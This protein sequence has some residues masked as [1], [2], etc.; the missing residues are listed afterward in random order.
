MIKISDNEKGMDTVK[1]MATWSK[2]GI[3]LGIFLLMV[4]E[5]CNAHTIYVF[6]PLT[7]RTHVI[8]KK[9]GEALPGFEITFFGKN[10][11]F[12]KAV[13]MSPP[14]AVFSKPFI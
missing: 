7:V 8:Q 1:R 3:L 9:L 13:E 10:R 2:K 11:D 4:A 5:T 6:Y 14:D 12:I